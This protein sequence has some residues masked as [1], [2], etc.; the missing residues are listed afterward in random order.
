MLSSGLTRHAPTFKPDS[1]LHAFEMFQYLAL[2]LFVPHSLCTGVQIVWNVV[3]FEASRATVIPSVS[4]TSGC[5]ES[6]PVRQPV[7][8]SSDIP[9]FRQIWR[10]SA[11]GL[12]DHAPP[13]CHR[14]FFSRVRVARLPSVADSAFF[15]VGTLRWP[16]LGIAIL[17]FV[18]IRHVQFSACH[19]YGA[20]RSGGGAEGGDPRCCI[21][22]PKDA[23]KWCR[24][25]VPRFPG[26]FLEGVTFSGGTW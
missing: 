4:D 6:F 10:P 8:I 26:Y 15:P 14:P 25:S 23:V 17:S 19:F 9:P 16:R 20:R 24:H 12:R 22:S 7:I 3:S 1:A 11:S 13:E 21:S 5:A 18:N 2:L